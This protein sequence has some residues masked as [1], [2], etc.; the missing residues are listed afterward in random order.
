MVCLAALIQAA[1]RSA[2]SPGHTAQP[3]KPNH[4]A[5]PFLVEAWAKDIES[6]V[7][8]AFCSLASQFARLKG[9]GIRASAETAAAD[10]MEGDLV[11]VD[12]PYSAVHY[13][14]FYHVLETISGGKKIR[15]DG[16]GRYPP[17]TQRPKSDFSIST[18]SA[19]A[20]KELLGTIAQR[21]ATVILTFPA[22]RCSNGLSGELVERVA[23]QFFSVE[24]K[25]VSSRFST[26]GGNVKL[27]A[28]RHRKDELILILKPR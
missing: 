10:V 4:T 8:S 7:R 1:S 23:R 22:T 9:R 5:G 18:K 24:Q 28:A 12:P 2:A 11:F 20:L 27:R 3:F 19:P 26:L 15:V 14:R 21:R 25:K 13:S 17:A 6:E 16:T